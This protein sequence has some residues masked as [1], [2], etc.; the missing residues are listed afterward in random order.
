MQD[1]RASAYAN[2]E[3]NKYTNTIISFLLDIG[4]KVEERTIE[5]DTFLPGI[6]ID[7]GT[8]AID[9]EKMLYP[10]DLLHEAGHLAVVTPE[11]RVQLY[12]SVAADDSRKSLHGMEEMSAI[13]WSYAALCYLNLPPEVVFHPTGYKGDSDSMIENF[14][15][16]QYFGVSTLCWMKLCNFDKVYHTEDAP[17]PHM[18]RWMRE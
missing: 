11:D 6:L 12:N 7:H 16:G 18:I 5:E 8:L 13:A 17:Y 9:L 4:I 15:S 2:I 3:E 1:K 10:G 14:G